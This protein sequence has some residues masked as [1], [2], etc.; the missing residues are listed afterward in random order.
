MV[1]VSPATT[2]PA[3]SHSGCEGKPAWTVACD[4]AGNM[5]SSKKNKNPYFIRG[6]RYKIL[7]TP[8]DEVNYLTGYTI[9]YGPDGLVSQVP[10]GLSHL[11]RLELCCHLFGQHLYQFTRCG[12]ADRIGDTDDA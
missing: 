6:T 9:P 11:Y 7:Y 1:T 12:Q 8:L 4:G 2:C 5:R 3:K 10:F